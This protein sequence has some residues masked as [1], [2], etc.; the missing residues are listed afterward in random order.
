V[1]AGIAWRAICERRRADGDDEFVGGPTHPKALV[2][3]LVQH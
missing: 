3:V 2:D 1:Q